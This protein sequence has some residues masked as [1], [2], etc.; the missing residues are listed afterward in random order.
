MIEVNY[1]G[2]TYKYDSALGNRPWVNAETN[3]AV[4][5]TL[6]ATLRKTA[7]DSGI[8]AD[9]F[10]TSSSEAKRKGKKPLSKKKNII[11]IF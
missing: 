1:N 5:V 8:N 3:V 6:Y 9:V 4:P 10:N 11:K 2:A 7:I